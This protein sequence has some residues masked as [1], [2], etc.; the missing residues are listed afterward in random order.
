MPKC[1][2]PEILK[3]E[4]YLPVRLNKPAPCFDT[5]KDEGNVADGRFSTAC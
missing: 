5:G 4:A 2:A 1:K 3:R